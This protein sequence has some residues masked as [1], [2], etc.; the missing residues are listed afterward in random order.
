MTT[1][2]RIERARR[3]G[4]ERCEIDGCRELGT[5]EHVNAHLATVDRPFYGPT[6]DEE[7]AFGKAWADEV[8]ANMRKADR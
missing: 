4:G 5:L 2:E 1:Q 3:F 7:A 8:R 6:S